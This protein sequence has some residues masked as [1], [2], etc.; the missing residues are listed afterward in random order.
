MVLLHKLFSL[1]LRRFSLFDLLLGDIGLVGIFLLL[2][3]VVGAKVLGLLDHLGIF[4]VQ[5]GERIPILREIVERIRAQNDVEERSLA[6]T[7]HV[8]SALGKL[9]LQLVDV[10][11]VFVD[12]G[13]ALVHLGDCLVVLLH[14]LVVI[15]GRSA[16]L[17]A[18]RIQ[19]LTSFVGL[20]LHIGRRRVSEGIL[21]RNH[22]RGA[23]GG[24]STE[25]GSSR[26][27]C[28]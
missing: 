19:L 27:A 10:R 4:F 17:L 2:G 12:L 14:G 6:V 21:R 5:R 24:G 25:E 7:V 20:S 1:L 18:H 3:L 26:Q 15:R 28:V 23:K 9:V 16:K 8:A 11:V 22:G 13:L